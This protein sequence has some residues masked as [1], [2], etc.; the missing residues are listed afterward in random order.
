MLFYRILLLSNLI[1]LILHSFRFLVC[2]IISLVLLHLRLRVLMTPARLLWKVLHGLIQHALLGHYKRL[3]DRLPYFPL[4]SRS[5]IRY[6]HN[7]VTLVGSLSFSRYRPL[8]A[9]L[10]AVCLAS[11]PVISIIFHA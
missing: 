4:S 10:T 3:V 2:T 1:Y 7:I 8:Y 11:V 6:N 5:S 9:M